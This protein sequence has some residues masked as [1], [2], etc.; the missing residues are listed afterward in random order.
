MDEAARFQRVSE[1]FESL[2]DLPPDQVAQALDLVEP[3]EIR[4]EIAAMLA[5]D[6]SGTPTVRTI[7]DVAGVI[8]EVHAPPAVPS[9]I[10]QY[11]VLGVIGY[12]ATGVVLRGR[13]LDGGPVVAIKVLASGAWNPSA[14][15]RF[16]REVRLLERL[17]H[18]GIARMIEAGTDTSGV[19]M[20]PFFVMEYIEGDTLSAWL[21]AE[22]RDL[23]AILR[24][25]I[26]IVDAVGY[27]HAAG[28]V[29]RDLKPGNILVS[30][31]GRAKVL[32]FGV[33]SISGDDAA[34]DHLRTLTRQLGLGR[35]T[36]GAG[37]RSGALFGTLPYMSPEQFGPSR[38]I[39]WRSDLYAIGVML[40][41][42]LAGRLPYRSSV[43][44]SL[45]HI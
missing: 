41:E 13:H 28:V 33:A 37:T 3:S 1:L 11:E 24:V 7:V 9:R 6:R 30:S 2:R 17:S 43:Q 26:D 42:A 45:I 44:L 20:Q 21:R 23:A 19:A 39:D 35:R 15:A 5:A 16:R 22:P 32:D 27:A 38:K 40:F 4:A 10:A 31:A 36:I 18:P 29:H 12:G 25:F 8:D 34:S 14:L